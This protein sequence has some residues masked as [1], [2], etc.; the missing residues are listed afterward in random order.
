MNI[1]YPSEFVLPCSVWRLYLLNL[2]SVGHDSGQ[3]DY[4]TLA[5][6][7]AARV[8]EEVFHVSSLDLLDSST[9]T[10]ALTGGWRYVT[11]LQRCFADF[12]CAVAVVLLALRKMC[13]Y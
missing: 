13:C 6:Q 12:E 7:T 11:I 2:F 10:D 1:H 5:N 9:F 8:L 3:V 4:R